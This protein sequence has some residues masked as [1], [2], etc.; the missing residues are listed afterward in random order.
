MTSRQPRKHLSPRSR[1]AIGR[2]DLLPYEVSVARF[3]ML[4]L[5]VSATEAAVQSFSRDLLAESPKKYRLSDRLDALYAAYRVEHLAVLCPDLEKSCLDQIEVHSTDSPE[6]RANE[7]VRLARAVL[8]VSVADAA[9]YFARAVE[10]VSKFGDELVARW[11]AV[12]A[13]ASRAADGGRVSDELAYRYFRCAELVGE[14]VIREKYWSR[15][16]G[17]RVGVRLHAPQAFAAMSRWRDREVGWFDGPMS[18]LA[19]EAVVSGQLDANAAWCLSGFE[20]C[21]SNAAFAGVCIDREPD[22]GRRQGILDAAARDLALADGKLKEWRELD[23]V[24]EEF[25]LDRMELSRQVDERQT[26]TDGPSVGEPSVSFGKAV[27]TD[28]PGDWDCVFLG[29]DLLTSEGIA[30]AEAGYR[31]ERRHFEF[32]SFWEEVVT[33]IPVGRETAFLDSVTHAEAF[34][35]WDVAYLLP[36]IRGRWLGK[37]SVKAAWAEFLQAVGRRWASELADSRRLDYWLD[38][39]Y[40]F[41]SELAIVKEGVA[42]G[43]A[44]SVEPANAETFFGFIAYVAKDLTPA[45]CV[46][47]L[48]FGLSR[49]EFHLD[50]HFGDGPWAEWLVVPTELKSAVTGLIWSALGSP[51]SATRWQATHCVRRLVEQGCEKEIDWLIDWMERDAVGA[52]GSHRFPFYRLHARLYLLVALART[53]C[54]APGSLHR[55]SSVFAKL[56]LEGIPHVLI[57]TT[58]ARIAL[59]MEGFAPGSYPSGTVEKLAQIGRSRIRRSQIGPREEPRETPWHLSGEVDPDLKVTFGIDFETTGSAIWECFWHLPAAGH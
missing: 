46:T 18:A 44:D 26:L 49:F 19:W 33:R 28:P 41:E 12:V 24:A 53:T 27:A 6:E 59:A 11:Q 8:S 1:R 39:E 14:S 55:H 9:T 40:L 5:W 23:A 36:F 10:A 54:E 21:N 51:L 30:R 3:E 22:A 17:F 48:D 37:A 2:Y 45:D 38:A 52:F 57:Q 58:A 31:E 34:D 29:L 20:A 50:D 42:Q 56:A 7:Y 4:A 15:A 47:I 25:G 35:C 13:V 16:D 43:L 32:G